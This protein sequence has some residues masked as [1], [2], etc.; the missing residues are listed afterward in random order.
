[1]LGI[2]GVRYAG[3]HLYDYPVNPDPAALPKNSVVICLA[4]GKQRIEAAFSLFADGVGESLYIVGAGKNANPAALSRMQAE[5]VAQK[6]SWDRFDKILVETESRNTMENAFVVKRFLE[7]HPGTKTIVLVTSSYH[8][9]RARFMIA[10]QIP[11]DVNI[12][13]YA[14]AGTEFERAT[15]WQSWNGISVTTVEYFKFLLASFLV[16]RLGYF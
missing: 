8:M 3:D 4:G 1:M 12:I 5:K 2:V 14:P 11:L 15:W 7:Q 6:I 16:P 13:P 9:R 10:H